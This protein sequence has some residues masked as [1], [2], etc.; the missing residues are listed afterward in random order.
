MIIQCI[1]TLVNLDKSESSH[2]DYFLVCT[3]LGLESREMS[4]FD[5]EM[6]VAINT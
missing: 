4:G 3:L 5:E 2:G 6:C 1:V